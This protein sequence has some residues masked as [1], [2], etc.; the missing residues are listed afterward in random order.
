MT[1]ET[2]TIET[3]RSNLEVR[4]AVWSA[5][6]D[7]QRAKNEAE[8]KADKVRKYKIRMINEWRAKQK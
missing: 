5:T 3:I 7:E 6:S 2:Q 8:Y 1:Y 4:Q